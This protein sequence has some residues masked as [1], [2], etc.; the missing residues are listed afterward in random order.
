MPV[1]WLTVGKLVLGNL[2]TI[3]NV[4][5]PAFTRKKLDEAADRTALLNQQIAELQ[6]AAASN[7]EQVKQLAEQ[8]KEVVAALAQSASEVSAE[9]AARRRVANLALGL[10]GVALL[11]SM[12]ALWS[13]FGSAA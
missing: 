8:L 13:T 2:D 4:V 12:V 6:T 10:A 3:M 5:R 11:C 7:A 9:R 1:P